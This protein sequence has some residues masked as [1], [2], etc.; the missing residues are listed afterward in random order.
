MS[1]EEAKSTEELL[2]EISQKL[3]RILGVIACQDKN[4]DVNSKI[5]ILR[6]CGFD[7]NEIGPFVNLSGSAVRDKKG[8]KGK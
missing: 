8:W 5:K 2:S 3:D 7:S 6:N 4:L 1:K